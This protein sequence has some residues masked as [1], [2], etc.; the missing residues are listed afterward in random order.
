MKSNWKGSLLAL[1][2]VLGAW[3][4]GAATVV[5]QGFNINGQTAREYLLGLDSAATAVPFYDSANGA[6][7]DDAGT[8]LKPATLIPPGR[9]NQ[10]YAIT[11]DSSAVFGLYNLISATLFVD[12]TSINIGDTVNVFANGTL[13]GSLANQLG[14]GPVPVLTGG[15]TTM[16]GEN[17]NT[18]FDLSGQL[19]NLH[20]LTNFTISFV[21]SSGRVQLDGINIQAEYQPVVPNPEPATLLFLGSGLVGLAGF[22]WRRRRA[23]E[24]G[25]TQA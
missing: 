19:A 1:G 4:A 20:D 22:G 14:P 7:N 24:A 17:D 21:H 16:A 25:T 8:I 18:V 23:S 5:N 10:E 12:A 13:L 2:I 3:Q 9:V 15:Y 6:I 11:F